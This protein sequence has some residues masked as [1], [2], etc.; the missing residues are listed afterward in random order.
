MGEAVVSSKINIKS[1][2]NIIVEDTENLKNGFYIF[3]LTA[4]DGSLNKS[5]IVSH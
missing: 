1:G 4:V 5:F 2:K 3:R